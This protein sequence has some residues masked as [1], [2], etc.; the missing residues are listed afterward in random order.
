MISGM[1][2]LKENPP[3]SM[4]DEEATSHENQAVDQHFNFAYLDERT[5]RMI[6]RAILKAVAIPGYQVPFGSREMPLPYGWG[7]GGI[8]V[9]ASVIGPQDVLKVID[10][11]SDDT[12]NAVN[13][14]RFFQRTT[15]VEI[16]THTQAATLIQT[17]HR[18]PEMA[19]TEDQIII[20][21]VPVPEP[22]QH[23]EPRERETRSLHGL[24]EY[25]LMHVKLYED[26][27]RYG[28]IATTY[29]YPVLVNHRYVMAPS[30]IPKFDNP[31]MHMNP[32]LQLFGAGREKRIYAV[33]PYTSVESLGFEDYPFEIQRW[34]ASCALCNSK[35][36][37][38]D[39]VITDDQG[40]RIFVCSDSDYCETQQNSAGQTTV[41]A[42]QSV[43][44]DD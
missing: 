44:K 25:G 36:S 14:R 19:L 30:P 9:T 24:A 42:V 12:V 20:Y 23:L 21:Q 11:G 16:T 18:I 38:L 26:I 37:F 3:I 32:A 31:K 41:T 35:D 10:Q 17:R 6:R 40:G 15:N 13:I 28:H 2:M 33:P 34:D 27:A 1:N 4:V 8:Q 7:T 22:M 43:S 29:D 39:E 5:K